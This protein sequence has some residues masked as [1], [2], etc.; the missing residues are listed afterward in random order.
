MSLLKQVSALLLMAAL[1]GCGST[2]ESVHPDANSEV[3]DVEADESAED[4]YFELMRLH[5]AGLLPP[6]RMESLLRA[7]DEV[8][9]RH[10]E[11]SDEHRQQQRVVL[12]SFLRRALRELRHG[13]DAAVVEAWHEGRAYARKLN[14]AGVHEAER[15]AENTLQI[16]GMMGVPTSKE[17][18]V[19]MV[20][21][22]VGGYVVVK[23]G[24]MLI[25]RAAFLMRKL[26][27]VDD[28]VEHAKVLKLHMSYA[29]NETELRQVAGDVAA[30]AVLRTKVH[31]GTHQEKRLPGKENAWN[32]SDR[33]DNC[34]AC[35]ATVIRNS[36]EGYFKYT[37]DEMEQLFGYTGRESR[38]S[39]EKSL[40]YIENATGLTAAP[41][42]VSM[43]GGA[44]VSHYA[45]FT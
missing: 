1:G 17:D 32:P 33:D 4:L 21:I 19:L 13:E 31:V 8:D 34:K 29:A 43:L 16:A 11:G 10:E 25:Q 15:Y 38:L 30:D 9:S 44:P 22:P 2:N 37:A 20:G 36:L 39:V 14:H 45:V 35:V 7:L 3:Y 28:V 23:A 42:P 40:K 5:S 18:L 41:T 6:G 26:R 24:G 12:A 27:S